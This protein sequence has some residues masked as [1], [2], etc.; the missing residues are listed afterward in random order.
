MSKESPHTARARE[1]YHVDGPRIDESLK[2]VPTM[3]QPGKF[4]DG[5]DRD[6]TRPGNI[7][8]GARPA[9]ESA[10]GHKHREDLRER[11]SG[12]VRRGKR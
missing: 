5:Q 9:Y 10:E 3:I 4:S 12:H 8:R 2:P 7:Y 1:L 6:G 11:P